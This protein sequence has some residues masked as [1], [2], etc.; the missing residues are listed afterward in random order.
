MVT[1]NVLWIFWISFLHICKKCKKE[2]GLY[3]KAGNE[4]KEGFFF[5]LQ[6]SKKKICIQMQ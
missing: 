5:F 2:M 4:G 1:Y 3:L 6:W